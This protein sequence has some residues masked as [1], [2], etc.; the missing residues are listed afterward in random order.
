M[1]EEK[2]NTNQKL[3]PSF[4][5]MGIWA[6]SIGTSIGWGSFVVTCSTYLA[7]AGILG[8]IFGIILGMVVILVVN[9]NLCYMM[10]RRPD[11]GGIYSYASMVRGHDIG[12]LVAWFLLLTYMAILWANITS[13]PLFAS[14]FLGTFF[15]FGFHYSIFGYT[16]YL[17][18]ALLS[19]A[20]IIVVGLFCAFSRRLPQIIMIILAL[21]FVGGLVVVTLIALSGHGFAPGSFD[22]TFAPEKAEVEQILRIAVISPWAFIGFENVAHFSEEFKFPVKKVRSVMLFSVLLTTAVYIFMTLLSVSAFPPEYENWFAYIS[23]MGNLSG[24][25]AIPAFYAAEHYLGSGGIVIMLGALLAVILTSIIGN[26]T[27]ISRLIYAFGRDHVWAGSLS[28]L[29]KKGIPNKAIFFTV[30]ISC[31]I[32]FI[33]RTAIGWIVDVTTLG[34]TIIYGFLSYCVYQDAKKQGDMTETMTGGCGAVIMMGVA[35][36]LLA[37]K[38]I[39]YEAMEAPSYLLFAVWSLLGLI[40][41]RFVLQKDSL[42][43]Y[44]HSVVV[45][46]MLL[47]L[48]LLTTM[49]WTNRLTQTAAEESIVAVQKH[50]ENGMQ[51]DKQEMIDAQMDKIEMANVR[52]TFASFAM[53]LVAVGI[54]A[55]NYGTARR[56][57]KEW[58]EK[59]G[60]AK[61]AGYTDSLTGVKNR[62]AYS[63]YENMINEKIDKS[64]CEPFALVVCD[65]NNLKEVNDVQ[66]H[67]AGD[68]CIRRACRVICKS[69]AHS[70]VFRYGGDEFV[71][72]LRGEDY[73]LRR[74]LF[75]AMDSRAED[76]QGLGEVIAVGMAE[77][78]PA[79]HNSMLRVF[80]L[81]DSRMY[82]R[83]KGLK[84]L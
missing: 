70:P 8:T 74:D 77:Y 25:K 6:F 79:V 19:I 39:A 73:E 7:Q 26:L 3:D 5:R 84:G 69:F 20:A 56:R 42:N 41:F 44:G 9:R 82:E 22:P 65:I 75:K 40:V 59:L 12:F 33:G 49:M 48:M 62:L 23:D 55:N 71:V 30:A 83:K 57:E 38:L 10:S 46:V 43:R 37:P 68:E 35:V 32:P 2:R 51:G 45:W 27:A 34:A 4:S 31:A 58:M 64:E 29:N 52:S 78:N 21:V 36:L 72:L 60:I 67:K 1:A 14:R 53:F 28:N 13:L 61:E 54:M 76:D 47:L 11:A 15:Q 66:G 24:I 81:A 18:E 50:Y 16:V 80:E 63:Q 17:G